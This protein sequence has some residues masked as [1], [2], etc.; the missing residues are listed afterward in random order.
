MYGRRIK[1]WLPAAVAMLLCA[2]D[3]AAQYYDWGRS[4]SSIRWK[5]IEGVSGRIIYPDYFGDGALRAR[6]YIEAVNPYISYGFKHPPLKFPTVLHTQNLQPNGIVIWAPKRMEMIIFPGIDTY[7][8]PWLKQLATHEYRH[9]AQY[10]NLYRGWMK[11][12]GWFV[13]QHAGLVSTILAPLWLLEGDA[14]MTETQMSSFGRALQ[15]SFTIEYR[16]YFTEGNDFPID[17]WF[18][19]SFRHNIPDHYQFGY[20]LTAWGRERYGDDIWAHAMDFVAHRPYTILPVSTAMRKLYK[21]SITSL[22]RETIAELAGFWKNQPVEDNTAGIIST[23][24]TGFTTYSTPMVLSGSKILAVKQDMDRTDRIVEV[25]AVSGEERV[26]F[27][28]GK[29]VTYPV[30]KKGKVYWT[31]YR[32]STLWDQRV[33]SRICVYDPL[34]GRRQV[35]RDRRNALFPTPMPD[36]TILSVGYDYSGIY[37]LENETGRLADFPAHLSVHGLALDETTGTLAFIGNCDNGMYL[38]RIDYNSGEYGFSEI[39]VPSRVSIRGLQAGEGKLTFGSIASG[40]DEV[41]IYDLL[42]DKEY[43]LTT[44]RY[45]SFSP[46]SPSAGGEIFLTTYTPQGYLLAKQN[47]IEDSLVPVTYSVLPRNTVNPPRRKWDV[48]NIDTVNTELLITESASVK[49]K[50]FRKLP[51][52]FNFHS[53]A[54]WNFDPFSVVGEK[55]FDFS[56]GATV[57]TQDILSSTTGFFSYGYNNS[58][59]SFRGALNYN[60]L[61]PRIGVEFDYGG[62]K[63]VVYGNSINNII[64]PSR[65]RHFQLTGHISLPMNL[66]SGSRI[67]ILT[68]D[69]EMMHLNALLLSEDG[70]SFDNGYQRMAA[71]LT[72][73]DNARMSERDILPRTGYA[74]KA[75]SVSAPFNTGFGRLYSVYGR[76]FLPGLARQNVITLKANYQYQNGGRYNF[77]YKDLFPRGAAYNFS[78][79]KYMAGSVEYTLPLWYPDGGINGLVFFRRVRL[80]AYFDYAHYLPQQIAGTQITNWRNLT[81]YGGT[82]TIDMHLLRIP[83][84]MASLGVY[85]YRPEGIRGVVSGV[86]FSLPL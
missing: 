79:D 43:R 68:P 77:I 39:T 6:G 37:Y 32:S 54:P 71:S 40:K 25:D 12:L 46:S 38:G 31:E 63:Q 83:V 69:L 33:F 84:N 58:G 48:I 81:S 70:R 59:H 34:S 1:L 30:L 51:N 17:K 78:P 57:M 65:N 72:Y 66:S 5:S 7:A 45:G 86:M 21:T 76:A 22:A 42:R 50:K 26:L 67:R 82:L 44:S 75:A 53:W 14:T 64:V 73:I 49:A 13:G 16:A 9:L 15:P 60:G 41:H 80:N 85:V 29:I 27:F 35:I 36:G 52:L 20:Q 23:P 19:G 47:I 74:F 28:T 18:C 3:S 55:E 11:P 56:W 4:P 24:L 61:A 8:Q 62:G 2:A 10:G